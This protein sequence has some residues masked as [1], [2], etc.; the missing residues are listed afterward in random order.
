MSAL[1]LNSAGK[2]KLNQSVNSMASFVQI[3]EEHFS[4]RQKNILSLLFG[5]SSVFY[6]SFFLARCADA[7]NFAGLLGMEKRSSTLEGKRQ[8]QTTLVTPPT[9]NTGRYI[10][11]H[12]S[13]TFCKF[14]R[15]L[16]IFNYKGCLCLFRVMLEDRYSNFLYEENRGIPANKTTNVV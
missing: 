2:K 6:Y 13:K 8:N 9:K 1:N 10:L 12:I 4:L 5:K 11:L 7:K 14:S 16:E 3:S 15:V